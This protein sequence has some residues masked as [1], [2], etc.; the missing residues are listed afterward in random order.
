M[1]STGG[2]K[3]RRDPN[4]ITILKDQSLISKYPNF[5]GIYIKYIKKT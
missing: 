1:N 3:E 4:G 5:V 2:I